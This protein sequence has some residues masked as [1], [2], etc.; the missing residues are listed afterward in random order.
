MGQRVRVGAV[1]AE[2]VWWDLEGSLSKTI[3]HIMKAGTKGVKV[4]GLPEV[5]ICGYPW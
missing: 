3:D 1:Q 4:L 5:W 2:P